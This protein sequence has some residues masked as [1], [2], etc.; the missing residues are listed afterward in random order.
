[1][2]A[3][4]TLRGLGGIALFLLAWQAVVGSGLASYDYLPSPVAI[5]RSI[6]ELVDDR[7]VI[8]ETLH[9]L[10]ATLAGWAIAI[11][12]GLSLG[13]LLG[14]SRTAR[15]YGLASVELLRPVPAVALVPAAMLLFGF[16]IQTE[17]VVIVIPTIWP[18]L[19]S[20]MR[21]IMAVPDRLE[22]V[23]RALRLGRV[24]TVL[25]VLIPAAAPA[26]LVGLRLAMTTALVLAVVA[27]MIG[28]PEGIGY[29]V[30]RE[31]QALHPD[32]MFAYVLIA[33]LLGILLNAA[34]VRL[35]RLILPGV[36]NRP[37]AVEGAP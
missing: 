21:G 1:M 25:K 4:R 14:F 29:A 22:D 36:F 18:V 17:L 37:S 31:A 27:E 9:T 20:T 32:L 23:A 5:A 13:A 11:A 34:L 2:S 12:V 7:G 26:V 19:V 30:V 6:P 35:A 16:S 28:N 24:E 8:G 15:D 3:A 33:G 10:G